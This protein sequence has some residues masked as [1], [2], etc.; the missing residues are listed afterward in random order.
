[1]S[2]A[3]QEIRTF[4]ITSSTKDRHPIFQT[5]RMARLFIDVLQDNRRKGRF[6][7]HEFVVMPDHFHLLMTPAENVPIEKA[8]QYIKGGFSFRAAKELG[9]KPEI[10][11]ESFAERRIKDASDYESHRTYI[12]QNPVRR[13]LVEKPE[14]YPYSSA[15]PATEVDARPS[16]LEPIPRAK[17]H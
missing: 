14:M 11:Q 9:F 2:H 15:N 13:F 17:A 5:E 7:L 6:Q 3:P 8:V 1:M 12:W 10:W 4:F 16:W